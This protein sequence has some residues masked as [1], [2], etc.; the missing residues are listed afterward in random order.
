MTI[1]TSSIL[2]QQLIVE[3][4]KKLHRLLAAGTSAGIPPKPA[5]STPK[6]LN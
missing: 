4:N 2:E 6:A 3:Q 5:T 1:A